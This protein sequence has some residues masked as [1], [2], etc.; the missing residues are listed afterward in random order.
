MRFRV[1]VART[2]RAMLGAGPD[3][4]DLAQEVFIRFFRSV[5]RLQRDE[6]LSSFM[7]G[8]CVRVARGELR[9]RRVHGWLRLSR[10]GILPEPPPMAETDDADVLRRLAL[11]VEHLGERDGPLFVLRQLK[12]LELKQIA[13]VLGVSFSTVRRRIDRMNA[14]AMVMIQRDPVLAR[15]FDSKESA[16]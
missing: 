3:Q 16:P 14:R 7:I 11:F 9:R 13:E 1:L 15:Y 5:H 4:Q 8:I 6:A 2:L 12:G 10:T